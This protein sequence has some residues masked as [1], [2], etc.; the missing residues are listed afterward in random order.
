MCGHEA[1][2]APAASW[3]VWLRGEGSRRGR[4]G[5]AAALSA[6][7][8]RASAAL[9]GG[10]G[11]GLLGRSR[12]ALR[13]P[14]P[15]PGGHHAPG[16]VSLPAALCAGP[17][18]PRSVTHP[19]GGFRG[20]FSLFSLGSDCAEEKAPAKGDGCAEGAMRA[21][22]RKADVAT[23]SAGPARRPSLVLAGQRLP[24]RWA[25]PPGPR[26]LLLGGWGPCG[27]LGVEWAL[28]CCG[29]VILMGWAGVTVIN[30]RLSHALYP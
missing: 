7:C 19:W 22:K 23:V 9:C 21:R 15:G 8:A 17:C 6:L 11:P 29:P 16:E 25:W 12:T 27:A 24:R 5:A 26:L 13:S 20:S 28:G 2:G 3:G 10:W 30:G 4:S 18:R 14:R 1:A